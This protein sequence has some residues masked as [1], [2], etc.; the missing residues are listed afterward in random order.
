M[1]MLAKHS[2]F[3]SKNYDMPWHSIVF[4][5]GAY[6]TYVYGFAIDWSFSFPFLSPF[7]LAFAPFTLTPPNSLTF[8][9]PCYLSPR[10]VGG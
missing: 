2:N 3:A 8:F 1:K 5:T 10:S 6:C 7:P 9:L 4:G